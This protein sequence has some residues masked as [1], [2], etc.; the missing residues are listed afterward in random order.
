MPIAYWCILVCVLAPYF[1]SVAARSEAARSRYV[2]DPRAYS[3]GLSGWR[4]RAHL[5]HLNAF[6]ATPAILAG[7]FVAELAG[8]PRLHVDLLAVAFVVFRLLHALLYIADKPMLRSHAW[9]MGIL[10]VIALFADA[11]VYGR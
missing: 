7:V 9:R 8:A 10:C 6:E 5:A 1:L 4:R 3:E 11:A 2:G